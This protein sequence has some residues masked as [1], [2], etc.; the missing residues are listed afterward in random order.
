[1]RVGGKGLTGVGSHITGAVV[2]YLGNSPHTGTLRKARPKALPNY[3][4]KKNTPQSDQANCHPVPFWG[5]FQIIFGVLTMLCRI[6]PDAVGAIFLDGLINPGVPCVDD[7]LILGVEVDEG[8]SR[9]AE[10]AL[11]DVGLRGCVL[12]TGCV[13]SGGVQT[14]RAAATAERERTWLL[15][16]VMKQKGW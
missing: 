15:K 12:A 4:K 2:Q 10:G 5:R 13:C 6:D 14:P 8:D 7:V 16:S 1:M 11:L 3:K 9:I